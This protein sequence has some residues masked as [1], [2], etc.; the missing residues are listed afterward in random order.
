[1]CPHIVHGQ[2]FPILIRIC[3][4]TMAEYPNNGTCTTD[5]IIPPL[6]DV[7]SCYFHKQA[8]REH[9]KDG[10]WSGIHAMTT[11]QFRSTAVD[12]WLVDDEMVRRESISAYFE[13]YS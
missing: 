5:I 3:I 2:A 12:C 9:L 8:P 13:E 10:V 1:M 11:H 4:Q 7:Q 6:P